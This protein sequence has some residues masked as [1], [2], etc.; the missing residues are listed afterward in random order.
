MLHAW[1]TIYRR[2]RVGQSRNTLQSR[3]SVQL[4]VADDD[5]RMNILSGLN[6]G[7]LLDL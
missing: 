6:I 2:N 3:E 4:P 7:Y 1:Q 5:D